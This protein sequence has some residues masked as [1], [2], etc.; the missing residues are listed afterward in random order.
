[1]VLLKL[2]LIESTKLVK[3]SKHFPITSTSFIKTCNKILT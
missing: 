1:M 2:N 3:E